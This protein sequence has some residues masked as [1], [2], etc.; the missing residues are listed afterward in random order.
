MKIV[1][2]KK[3]DKFLIGLNKYFDQFER[4]YWVQSLYPTF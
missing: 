4:E 1:E 2:K 3:T